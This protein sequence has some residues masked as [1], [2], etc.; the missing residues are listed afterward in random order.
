MLFNSYIFIFAFLPLCIIG[1]F[2][3]NKTGKYNLGLIFLIGMSLWFYGYYNPMYLII[4]VVSVLCNFGLY[5]W[6]KKDLRHR[7]AVMILGVILN[8]AALGYF[9]YTDFFIENINGI[10]RTDIGLLNIALPLGISFFTFQQISFIVDSYKGEV[11]D[12]DFVSYAAFVTFFPQLIAGPIV[13]HDELV[14]QFMD[15]D[16]KKA[17][18]YNLSSGLYMFSIGLAKKVLLAD[19]FSDGVT[20]GYTTV[21]TGN[22]TQAIL[23]MLAYTLQLYFDFSGYCDMAI[24]IGRMLNIELPVNFDSPYK[25]CS[26]AEFWKRWHITLTRFFTKYVY[27]PLGGSRRKLPRV[28]L[29]VMIVFFLSGLWHGAGWTFVVW[30]VGHGI[31]MVL[32]RLLSMLWKKIWANRSCPKPLTVILKIFGW[33]VTFLCVNVLWVFFRADSFETAITL[34][35]RI[36]EFNFAGYNQVYSEVFRVAEIKKV[37]SLVGAESRFPNIIMIGYFTAGMAIAVFGKN[38][39]QLLKNFKPNFGRFMV[40]FVLMLWSILSLAGL[41]TFLYFNF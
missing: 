17:D 21:A 40:T 39:G 1:Y 41:S 4:I 37:L 15:A 6:M 14:P 19:K 27:I 36:A 12:Y 5:S 35:R 3:I 23:T 38:A 2:L 32:H 31:L 34:L 33:A 11:P 16:K 9:K 30:G 8:L 13:T 26:I 25:S 20:Y 29:N 10:F 22:S 7:K 28:L 18:P 24:G